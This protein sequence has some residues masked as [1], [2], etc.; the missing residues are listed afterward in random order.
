MKKLCYKLEEWLEIGGTRKDIIL[1]VIAGLA[2]LCSI[3]H[4]FSLPFDIAW[5]AI[6]LCGVPI[7]LEAVIGLVTRF[8]IKADVLVSMA[9][10]ASVCIGEDFAAGEVAFIMQLG[11]LL[12]DLTV[13]KARAGIE[14]L[15]HLSPQTA[16]VLGENGEQI[17]P[18]EQVRVADRI[19][20]LPGETIPVD[21]V[22][23]SGQTSVNQAVMTGE[24]LPVDK[25][26]GDEVFSGT[27]NQFGAFE[28][29]ATKVGED[30]SIQRMIRLVQSADAG[31]AKIVGLA[32]RWATWIVVT[33]LTAAALTWLI[34]GQIIRAV[35]ILVVFCPCAL[36][37]ATPTAVVAAIGNATKHGFLVREGDALERLAGVKKITFDKTGT[38][39][40]GKPEVTKVVVTDPALTEDV[41]YRLVAAAE[42]NSEHPLG[43]AIVGCYQKKY[44]EKPVADSFQMLP[45]KGIVAGVDGREVLAG[46]PALM[47]GHGVILTEAVY[48]MAEQEQKQGATIIYIAVDGKQAGFFALADT[49]RSESVSMIQKLKTLSVTPVLL[50][51]DTENVARAI[52]DR[53]EIDQVRSSCLPEDKLSYI[54][55]LQKQ[56]EK[57]C[58]IGDGINDA[59]ALKMADVGIAMGGI[60]SD[61]AVDAADIALV[62]DKVEQLPH[63]FALAGRMMRTIRINLTF[64]MTLNFVAIILAITGI[65]N[66]VVGALVHNAGSVLVITHSALLLRFKRSD[67]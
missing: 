59:P 4:V 43:K 52:A 25:Q 31:K 42:G 7:I 40:Y 55:T 57:V 41:L 46:N 20:V 22:I 54:D 27:V 1:L 64:S 24:S 66:P 61:I 13:A 49:L 36:V 30:S 51:G 39:T 38:L 16:R 33:A 12:E 32:D 11:A 21:G 17:I 47:T 34:T 29:T 62:D 2:L 6:I 9:L 14:K 56:G 45:G 26:E 15:V 67:L 37:L 63:L 60:G 23:V 48:S 5:V 19:R 58:M 35:T 44:G 53:L 3:F 8:D 28:M 65:L 10:I 18:A 50:T